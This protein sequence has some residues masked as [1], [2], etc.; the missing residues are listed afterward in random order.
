MNLS[1]AAIARAETGSLTPT[2]SRRRGCRISRTTTCRNSSHPSRRDPFQPTPGPTLRNPREIFSLSLREGRGE[3]R[4][5]HSSLHG[6]WSQ[7]VSN[8]WKTFLSMNLPYPRH[9]TLTPN[10]NPPASPGS[11]AVSRSFLNRRLSMNRSSVAAGVPPAVEGGVSP[12]GILGSW[13]PCAIRESW[14]LAMNLPMPAIARAETGSL[15][16]T[17]SRGERVSRP[18]LGDMPK[19]RPAEPSHFVPPYAR[20][21][22]PKPAATILLL[23]TGQGRDEGRPLHSSRSA[24]VRPR[25]PRCAPGSRSGGSGSS[26]PS[27][28]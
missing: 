4:S 2:L 9:R 3:G 25:S 17:L 24:S 14:V 26:H 11:W 27:P 12:P 21:N 18:A 5:L 28:S 10:R 1:V 7:Y 6:S 20:L 13:S 8:F 19:P 16:P 23:P 15:T 22:P